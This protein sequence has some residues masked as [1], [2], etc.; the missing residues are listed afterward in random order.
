MW[1]IAIVRSISWNY[2]KRQVDGGSGRMMGGERESGKMGA[3]KCSLGLYSAPARR[4]YTDT[5][6]LAMDDDGGACGGG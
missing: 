6:S 4:R 5:R 3:I 2:N 1:H